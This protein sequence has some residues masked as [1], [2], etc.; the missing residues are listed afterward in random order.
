[1][2]VGFDVSHHF[3]S[4]CKISLKNS[5][6][7]SADAIICVIKLGFHNQNIAEYRGK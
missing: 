7:C 1:M 2:N 6:M 3:N 4:P 5:V